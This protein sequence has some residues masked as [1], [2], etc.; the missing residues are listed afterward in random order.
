MAWIV[1][2]DCVCIASTSTVPA[3]PPTVAVTL[4]DPAGDTATL[5][6]ATLPLK[7]IVT[8]VQPEA[9]KPDPVTVTLV[10][11]GPA[12]GLTVMCGPEA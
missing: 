9:Q 12:A 6:R 5:D 10:P 7:R 2:L 8:G 1:V 3:P 11:G 4:N